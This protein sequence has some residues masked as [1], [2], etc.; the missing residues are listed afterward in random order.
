MSEGGAVPVD[1]TPFEG[2]PARAGT[3]TGAGRG[4]P[5]SVFSHLDANVSLDEQSN[6]MSARVRISLETG[7]NGSFLIFRLRPAMTVRAVDE[8]GGGALSFTRPF[9]YFYN[10]SLGREVPAGTAL[11]I[12]LR[13]DGPVLNT[14][15]DGAS[16][17]DYV[18]PEG[19][20]VRTYGSYFPSDEN[21]SK[22][23]SRLS[24]TA[25]QD[26]TVVCSGEL[27]ARTPD[28][29]NGTVTAVYS[30]DRPVN[31][32]S[33]VAGRLVR[34]AFDQGGRRFELYFR[35]DHAAAAPSY[36]A[37]LA[38]ITGFYSAQFGQP[39]FSNLTVAEIPSLF[40]AW[41][42][43]TPS[44]MWLASRNFDGPLPYRIMSHELAHQWWGIDVEGE[45]AG[46]NFLQEGFAG[47]SEAMYEMAVYSSRGYLD[48]CRQQYINQ[49]VQAPGPEPVLVSNDYDLA[50]FKGPWVLH[51]LRYLVG[52]E[53]F[54][55]TLAALHR[56][57]SGGRADHF[58]LQDEVSQI[59]GR[60]LSGFFHM[61]LYSS[62]R[63]DY[64]ISDALVLQGPPGKDR[65]RLVVESRGVL[66]DLPMDVGIY[67]EGGQ[68]QVVAAGWNGSGPNVTLSYDV[69]YPV[70]AVKLDPF[71]WLLDAYPS[72]NEA[73]T[74]EG[75]FDISAGDILTTPAGPTEGEDI[76]V[77]AEV[78]LITSEGLTGVEVELQIDG[79]TSASTTVRLDGGG[80][81]RANFTVRLSP[82][83]H[84]LSAVS[85]P[86]DLLFEKD[87]LNN[88]ASLSLT[89]VPR[90]PVLPDVGIPPGGISVSPADASG[91]RPAFL[92]V[93][94]TNLGPA[95]A[96]GVTVDVW[97]D[98]LETGYLGRSGE[99]SLGPSDTAVARVPWTAVSGWHQL[100]AR[101]VMPPGQNDS[102]QR[103]D[104]A[105]T[106]VYVNSP[107]VALLWIS[108]QRPDT[109][110]WV[111]LSGLQSTDDTRVTHYFFDFGDGTD[112]GWLSEANTSHAYAEKGTYQARLAVQDDAGATGDWSVPVPVKVRDAPPMAA[113]SVRPSTGTVLTNFS[114]TS[115]SGDPDGSI[116]DTAWSFGDGS[117][118]R[119][120]RAFHNYS[121]HGD[122]LVSLT[123]QDDAGGTGTSAFWLSVR[124]LPPVPAISCDGR[125][126][127][128][129][130]KVVFSATKS[131]DMDDPPTA[132]SYV[133]DFGGGQKALG[134]DISYA[135][136]GPG[137][138][139]VT[140]TA[141]DGNL[142]AGC[143]VDVEVRGIAPVEEEGGTG[144]MAW[145]VLCLLLSAMAGLAAFIM[146]PFKQRDSEEEE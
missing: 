117:T 145:A 123:V 42:Q 65:V 92:D 37:E 88:R 27:V 80:R 53:S 86:R 106:Q 32:I 131:T 75:F 68:R 66:G 93:V 85:D 60:D 119:G 47:Y 76:A 134:P 67:F 132:L 143:W 30:N 139:R 61:W 5:N 46:E 13:Y 140:L 9:W 51:M 35:Q 83:K 77:S 15:D 71:N 14:P 122:F 20:W 78:A 6:S 118:A 21:S 109:G 91:G 31:G 11:N 2:A 50:S 120:E 95:P 103:N 74:R 57:R 107:P 1:G 124:D 127:R 48:F 43:S 125:P 55:R 102:D 63:L 108:D 135:F 3:G 141:S 99:L 52:D 59:T 73:P 23:T 41:G 112:S 114:F 69:G 87:E 10:V 113:L 62:G 22:T 26:K 54:N 28:P 72:N 34:S 128:V 7:R 133:W 45:G 8:E 104:E 129:G 29:V 84:A 142:T 39:G 82:G 96:K 38:R 97:V 40:A 12:T 70:D 110:E 90:P 105:T 111:D 64:A 19:S 138:H 18:G 58:A 100:T 130:Q 146:Y 24:V 144:P 81:A 98:S 16:Y 136:A 116:V 33:F 49:F 89:V 94:L 115:R 56:D 36:S 101:V 121:R 17:W 25:P 137:W 4:M 79:N 44:M 126:A